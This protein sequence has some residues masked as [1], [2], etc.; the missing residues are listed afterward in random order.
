MAL[1]SIAV[2]EAGHLLA[3]LAVGFRPWLVIIGP[4][5]IV[6]EGEALR[7]RLNRSLVPGLVRALP[8]DAR[9]LRRRLAVYVSGGPLATLLL[10]LV[11]LGLAIVAGRASTTIAPRGQMTF[12]SSVAGLCSLV[13][14]LITIIRFLAAALPFQ[15][16]GLRSDG[17]QLLDLLW[18]RTRAE[19]RLLAVTLGATW[20]N[21]VRPRAWDAGIVE[22]LLALRD[23]TD[24]DVGA[25]VCGYYHALD[26]GQRERAGRLLD[27]AASQRQGYPAEF[28]LALLLEAAFFE[29]RHRH[30]VAAA[31]AWLE[32][33]QGGH[34]ERFTR[35]RAE[36]AILWAEGRY[37]EAAVKAEAG[38]EAIPRSAACGSAVLE[39]EWLNSILA[40][41]R[42][43]TILSNNGGHAVSS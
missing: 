22:R 16:S 42:K 18:G 19:R 30:N 9:E 43:R 37:A 14:F 23:G 26:S 34:A 13:L 28:R 35:L 38:L 4:L 12:W 6:R 17:A 24:D 2:H 3:G 15:S 27:L 1:A 21:G 8:T 29:A 33:A 41:T 31:R 20:Q 7:V 40:E 25:N 10:G 11:C 32:Q 36:A 5:K 39:S